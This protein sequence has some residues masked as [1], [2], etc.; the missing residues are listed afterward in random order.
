M[1]SEET[2]NQVLSSLEDETLEQSAPEQGRD[3][4]KTG[5]LKLGKLLGKKSVLM[6]RETEIGQDQ[7]IGS[8]TQIE[9]LKHELKSSKAEAVENY[10]KYLRAV[11]EL[12]NFKKRAMKERSDIMKYQGERIFVDLLEIVDDFERALQHAE[13]DAGQLKSGLELI[14][15][16]FN[17]IL[18]K[19]EVKGESAIGKQFDPNLHNALSRVPAPG[20]ASGT[21]LAELK[22][23]YF[24]KDKLIRHG[25]V[26]V[27]EGEPQ[28]SGDS[29]GEPLE[30]TPEGD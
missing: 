6:E 22:K 28:E 17:S 20:T 29:S 7:D 5:P 27:A 14:L 16:R 15:K 11:A 3:S 10:D 8:D 12:D 2:D 26:M 21:I 30:N 19:W 4:S 24:Y 18:T 25:D 23:P 1:S 13:S 9:V